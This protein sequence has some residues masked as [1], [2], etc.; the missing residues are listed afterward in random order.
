MELIKLPS[1]RAATKHVNSSIIQHW[2]SLYSLPHNN[3]YKRQQVNA[4]EV[5]PCE[6]LTFSEG[7]DVG[8]GVREIIPDVASAPDCGSFETV[9]EDACFIIA[10]AGNR[11][12]ALGDDGVQ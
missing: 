3:A 12:G 7:L 9:G 8:V 2:W 10:L 11:C 4:D 6:L 5:F 1:N